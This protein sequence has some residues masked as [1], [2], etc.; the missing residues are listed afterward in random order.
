M[1][2]TSSTADTNAAPASVSASTDL[3][4]AGGVPL[5]APSSKSSASG[6]WSGGSKVAQSIAESN[7]FNVMGGRA[8]SSDATMATLA[9][10]EGERDANANP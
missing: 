2:T 7:A 9:A 10:M 5:P 3:A 4:P 6:S 8:L 1:W